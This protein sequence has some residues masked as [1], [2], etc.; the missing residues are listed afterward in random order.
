MNSATIRAVA[1]PS[2]SSGG[3]GRHEPE[4]EALGR[5]AQRRPASP[6]G[7]GAGRPA[8]PRATRWPPALP[9][10]CP[11][12]RTTHGGPSVG[13]RVGSTG[14]LACLA[15]GIRSGEL[16]GQQRHDP[17]ARDPL[18]LV[19]GIRARAGRGH[20]RRSPRR[21]EPG[22]PSAAPRSTAGPGSG[23]RP[24]RRRAG[25]PGT[26]RA[27]R[28]PCGPFDGDPTT[29]RGADGRREG[30][31]SVAAQRQSREVALEVLG[32]AVELRPLVDEEPDDA[33]LE[34]RSGPHGPR[35]G[36]SGRHRPRPAPIDA[37]R[38]TRARRGATTARDPRASPAD[39][40][41]IPDRRPRSRRSSPRSPV[42]PARRPG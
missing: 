33:P 3:R 31:Q 37:Q 29:Q 4:L 41:R 25:R 42:E 30:I 7:A 6:A 39:A 35:A 21:P 12:S 24:P 38:V 36:R 20:R 9:P 1:R 18:A 14:L 10:P 22:S 16:E 19:G 28:S 34:R 40:A 5:P 11:A 23:S 15:D 13:Q 27:S 2:G 32:L 17:F 26:W 8:R